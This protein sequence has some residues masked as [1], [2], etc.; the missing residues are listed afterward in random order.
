MSNKKPRNGGCTHHFN[1]LDDLYEKHEFNIEKFKKLLPR[2]LFG[3]RLILRMQNNYIKQYQKKLANFYLNKYKYLSKHRT[4]LI[5]LICKSIGSKKCKRKPEELYNALCNLFFYTITQKQFIN[6]V[7][8]LFGLQK[9]LYYILPY[10]VSLFGLMDISIICKKCHC[11]KKHY[12]LSKQP[13]NKSF[14]DNKSLPYQFNLPICAF[15]Y[16]TKKY[17]L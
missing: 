13:L 11:N 7:F 5:K 1:D 4:L 15:L 17:F 2:M 14:Y 16:R 12:N 3:K 8:E 6:F 9:T 10:F